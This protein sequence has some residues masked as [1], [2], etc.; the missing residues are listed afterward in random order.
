MPKRKVFDMGAAFGSFKELFFKPEEG[1]LLQGESELVEVPVA[2]IPVDVNAVNALV[3]GLTKVSSMSGVT[4]RDIENFRAMQ[5]F[6]RRGDTNDEARRITADEAL[7]ASRRARADRRSVPDPAP[8]LGSRKR[9]F[10]FEDE[11]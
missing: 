4:T 5:R 10:S 1:P 2:P 11:E 8:A 9:A 3:A 7:G 6:A